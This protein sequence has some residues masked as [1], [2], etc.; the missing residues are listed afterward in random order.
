MPADG[1][2]LSPSSS[3]LSTEEI[4][5]LSTIFV[6][7][8]GVKKI[9]LTGGEPLIRKD[10][11]DLVSQLN[12]LKNHGLETI[13]IT[14]NGIKLSRLATELKNNGVDT[15]NISLDTLKPSKFES[16]TRRNGFH[17]VLNGIRTALET[18]FKNQIKLNVVLMKNFNDDEIIDFINL[19]KFIDLDVR[20]I[21]YMPFDGNNWNLDQMV[22][23]KDVLNLVGVE[24]GTQNVMKLEPK[25]LTETSK[26]FKISGFVG[27]FGFISS[28]TDNF[29]ATCNRL[30]ITADGN[31][32]VS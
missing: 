13:G 20:F 22:P 16:I 17:L 6:A 1:V 21:E 5:K 29:C 25:S 27:Q 12:G 19:T 4:I 3:I 2:S 32:K 11:L 15:L 23:F 7:K 10:V 26:P 30:R 14:T 31:L 18:G 24:F 9:R 8:L 28:M